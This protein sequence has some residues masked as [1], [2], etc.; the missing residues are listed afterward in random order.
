MQERLL[1]VWTGVTR[2]ADFVAWARST[3]SDPLPVMSGAEA[4]AFYPR[5]VA[6]Y[7]ALLRAFPE[8]MRT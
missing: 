6:R 2:D 7:S 4:Q 5:E 8:A 3:G 1:Q